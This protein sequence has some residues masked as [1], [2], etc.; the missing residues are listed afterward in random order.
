MLSTAFARFEDCNCH[1]LPVVQDGRVVGIL[2]AQKVAD[3][4]TLQQRWPRAHR[5]RAAAA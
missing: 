1:I 4:L 2:T 3:L 5:P